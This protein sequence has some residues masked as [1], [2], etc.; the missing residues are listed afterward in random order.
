MGKTAEIKSLKGIIRETGFGPWYKRQSEE[1]KARVTAII[2][3]SPEFAAATHQITTEAQEALARLLKSLMTDGGGQSS[4]ALPI[5][6]SLVTNALMRLDIALDELRT[7]KKGSWEAELCAYFAGISKH[8]L[9]LIA[10]MMV[11]KF[12]M[13][14]K[15]Q[16][17]E[18]AEEM[19]HFLVGFLIE[20]IKEAFN[21]HKAYRETGV[22][23]SS[24]T[25]NEQLKL[26]SEEEIEIKMDGGEISEDGGEI[27]ETVLLKIQEFK[28]FDELSG[29][30][31]YEKK[32]SKSTVKATELALVEKLLD[33]KSDL[34]SWF[35][36]LTLEKRKSILQ[37]VK[38]EDEEKFI[39]FLTAQMEKERKI[40]K[41]LDG[42]RELLLSTDDKRAKELW[43]ILS[44][45][46]SGLVEM[47]EE[48][49][50]SE[51]GLNV[52][53]NAL[54]SLLAEKAVDIEPKILL[55]EVKETKITD[56]QSEKLMT[57]LTRIIET[58]MSTCFGESGIVGGN[59][60]AS[61]VGE[62]DV[63]DDKATED[64]LG[65]LFKEK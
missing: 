36:G 16:K 2:N 31:V 25:R 54:F 19:A 17:A 33:S 8:D 48:I 30:K 61:T 45:P 29:G 6:Y 50:D 42:V 4:G 44:L 15:F 7:Q 60:A 49:V 53:D 3:S 14:G 57:L 37:T 1:E 5:E 58:I 59:Q 20:A 26:L 32:P 39:V 34:F 38:P 41:L 22:W 27:A 55:G 51:T 18:K 35:K 23:F 40:S 13:V 46:L 65:D 62:A 11:G 63:D 47:A 12:K 43:E 21:G 64:L 24:L 10:E 28:I 52:D 56:E 9:Q